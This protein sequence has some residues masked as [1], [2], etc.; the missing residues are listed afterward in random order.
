MG[1]KLL[2]KGATGVFLGLKIGISEGEEVMLGN[3]KIDEVDSFTYLDRNNN[4]T[5]GTVKMLKVE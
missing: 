2:L 3:E 5:V 4:K 1:G